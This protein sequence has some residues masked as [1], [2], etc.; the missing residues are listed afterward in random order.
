MNI[1]KHCA[2]GADW[3]FQFHLK[4]TIL[5]EVIRGPAERLLS[6]WEPIHSSIS[7]EAKLGYD[8]RNHP[9]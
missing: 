8:S 5:F 7:N 3:K 4:F 2:Y 1:L 9:F 6:I